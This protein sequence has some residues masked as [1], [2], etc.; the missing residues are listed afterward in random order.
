MAVSIGTPER[1][2]AFVEETGFPIERLYA[3]PNNVCYDRLKLNRSLKNF[4]QKSTPEALAARWNKDGAKDLFD[5][6]K[7]W[8]PWTPPKPEQGFQQGGT[9]VFAGDECVYRF[10]DPST[11]VNAPFDDWLIAAGCEPLGENQ[12]APVP[13]ELRDGGGK[14]VGR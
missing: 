13:R 1:A 4:S 7:R 9:F 14:E 3:D 2:K 6:L 10:Y 5:V 12:P 11:G 8:K